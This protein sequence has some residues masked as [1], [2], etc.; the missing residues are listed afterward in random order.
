MNSP[1]EIVQQIP[2]MFLFPDMSNERQKELLGN[3][4]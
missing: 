4:A 2:Q 3:I 1:E